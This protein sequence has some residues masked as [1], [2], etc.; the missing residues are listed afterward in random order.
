MNAA[1]EDKLERGVKSKVR[2][3]PKEGF[4]PKTELGRK[5]WGLRQKYIAEGGRLYSDREIADELE[6]RSVDHD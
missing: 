1:L 5:L 6:R 2:A 3:A 4:V